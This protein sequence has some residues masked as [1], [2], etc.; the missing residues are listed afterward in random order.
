MAEQE[1]YYAVERLA[2]LKSAVLRQSKAMVVNRA[3]VEKYREADLAAAKDCYLELKKTKTALEKAIFDAR[4]LLMEVE[5]Y[6]LAGLAGKLSQ[7]LAGFDLMST[8]YKSVYDVLQSFTLR[9]PAGDTVNAKVVGRLMNQIKLGYYPTDPANIDLMLRGIT[10]PDGMTTNLLDPC[11]GCGK[12]LRQ[13]A[14]GNNCYTYGVELDESRAEEAQTR[15]HR[16]G[17]GSFFHSTVSHEAFHLLFLNPP[18]LSVLN[19]NGGKSRNEK[20]FLIE[21]I[22]CLMQGGLLIYVIPYYR[23]TPDICRVLTDNFDA[24]T[25]WR[26]T[27]AEFQH[28]RQ[29]AVMGIR[30]RKATEPG[31]T[32]QLERYAVS[33]DT[34]PSLS[35]MPEGR[36]TLPERAVEVATFKGEI[37]NERELEQQLRRS[38]SFEQMMTRSELD[39]GVKHPLLP[40]SI[41][42]IGLIGGSGMI[43]GLIGCEH[44]HIIK[45][46]IVKVVHTENEEKFTAEGKH[47]GTEVREVVTNKM[48]FNILTSQGFMS[49]T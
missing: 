13:L 14:Q 45:G 20:R 31:D 24:L 1:K 9:I 30:K 49:L 28:F 5:E 37:F 7:G 41:G 44:P 3:K 19:E 16:V 4:L 42:Q 34:I 6:E 26:F 21:S 43:N 33:P 38:D 27:D 12:A 46:R 2:E 25:V 35:E 18:Y 36:Y 17:F 15:L 32:L 39:S 48:I 22:R 29:V 47:M 8:N 23:L 40:L 10:F 11:C